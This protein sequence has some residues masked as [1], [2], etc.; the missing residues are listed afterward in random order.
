MGM[1]R[2]LDLCNT[3]LQEFQMPPCGDYVRNALAGKQFY[4]GSQ[5]RWE[6]L[7]GVIGIAEMAWITGNK[8]YF[9]AYQQIWWSLCQ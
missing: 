5:P 2:Y 4:Q 3:I 1:F 6:G 7:H 8:D 9:T